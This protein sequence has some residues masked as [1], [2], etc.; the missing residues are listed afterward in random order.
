MREAT[1]RYWQAYLK[2][3]GCIVLEMGHRNNLIGSCSAF[4]LPRPLAKQYEDRQ[5]PALGYDLSNIKAIARPVYCSQRA[6][7][8]GPVALKDVCTR[9]GLALHSRIEAL[10]LDT[11]RHQAI[12][13]AFRKYCHQEPT[14]PELEGWQKTQDFIDDQAACLASGLSK[15]TYKMAVFFGNVSV[16]G[17]FHPQI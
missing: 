4:V 5:H 6:V 15:N 2:T 17:V 9:A 14:R 12:K 7:I 16:M 10:D 13:D 3:A 11:T 1:L 8:E